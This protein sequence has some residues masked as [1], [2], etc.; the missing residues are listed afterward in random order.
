MIP[1]SPTS[2]VT[3]STAPETSGTATLTLAQG[4]VPGLTSGANRLTV[5]VAKST[6]RSKN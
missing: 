2:A 4:G 6:R 1:S 5:S 3:A